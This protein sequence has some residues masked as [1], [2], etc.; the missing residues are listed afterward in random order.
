[1]GVGGAL[2]LLAGLGVVGLRS[3][4]RE[5][6]YDPQAA[7]EAFRAAASATPRTTPSPSAST[8]APVAT[9]SSAAP[10][11]AAE[12]GS[13]SPG[14]RVAPA[15]RAP[16]SDAPSRRA[17]PL[18]VY[19]YDTSGYESV[20]ALGGARHDY[21]S[22]SAVTYSR[23]G[24][25]TEE[26]WQPLEGRIGITRTC[27]GVRGGEVRGTFQQREFFGR[28]QSETYVCDPGVLLLPHE[29][30]AGLAWTSSCTSGD[31]TATFAVRVV[32]LESLD[33]EGRAVPVVR[34]RLDGTLT[35]TTRGTS[36][37]EVW[38]A[39]DTGLLVQALGETDTDADTPAGVVR[40]RESYRLRLQSLT[41][42]R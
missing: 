17:V 33:V 42:R 34:V 4:D 21:P 32:A 22:S 14:V 37:R 3:A 9:R 27:P 15:P 36:A 12:P 39:E 10:S 41:P 18:G 2:V 13:T 5:Q 20:D 31:S 38:L 25:G 26:R 30:Q 24:C 28:S 6:P 16:G 23:S 29:P 35:G 11:P 7:V 19:G 8:R 1:M 40:Y